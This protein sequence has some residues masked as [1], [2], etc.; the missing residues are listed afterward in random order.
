MSQN[1]FLL[2]DNGTAIAPR[3]LH[4]AALKT[5]IL[6]LDHLHLGTEYLP[7]CDSKQCT[8]SKTMLSQPGQPPESHEQRSLYDCSLLLKEKG[9]KRQGN[10][11]LLT[12]R[13][14]I[15][16]QI[17]LQYGAD[18]HSEEESNGLWKVKCFLVSPSCRSDTEVQVEIVFCWRS[19]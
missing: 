13:Y 4:T 1:Q 18:A 19:D 11:F 5:R 15:T 14:S 8:G 2:S 17:F 6:S 10:P 7:H 9:K 16:P 3:I 12:P